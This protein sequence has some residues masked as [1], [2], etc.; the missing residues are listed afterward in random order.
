MHITISC[1]WRETRTN[2]QEKGV[3]ACLRNGTQLINRNVQ[4]DFYYDDNETNSDE[5]SNNRPSTSTSIQTNVAE[6]QGPDGQRSVVVSMNTGTTTPQSVSSSPLTRGYTHRKRPTSG[7]ADFVPAT[8]PKVR[9]IMRPTVEDLFFRQCNVETL[10]YW[11]MNRPVI[12][13]CWKV[14]PGHFLTVEI[15]PG[16]TFQ[17]F[18]VTF[19]RWKWHFF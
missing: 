4:H 8:P 1:L 9:Q 17:Q 3:M 6:H 18:G 10:P 16:V 5:F 14:T 15:W 12:F 11:K 2:T 7:R 13:Q 19:Q